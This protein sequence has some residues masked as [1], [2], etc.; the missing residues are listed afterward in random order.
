MFLD[1]SAIVLLIVLLDSEICFIFFDASSPN[2]S[3]TL[4]TMHAFTT[5]GTK[6]N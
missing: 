6:F 4:S 3:L 2:T 5:L 1:I